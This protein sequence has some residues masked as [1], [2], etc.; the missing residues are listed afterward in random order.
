M[1]DIFLGGVR[2]ATASLLCRLI[3][4]DVEDRIAVGSV[5][6]GMLDAESDQCGAELITFPARSAAHTERISTSTG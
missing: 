6:Y 4:L 1:G 2:K 5:V 3:C